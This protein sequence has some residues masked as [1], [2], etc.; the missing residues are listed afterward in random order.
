MKPTKLN[1]LGIAVHDLD[2]AARIYQALGLY[3]EKIVDVPEQQVR[4]A[5][6]PVGESTIEL[7][8]PT[9][10]DSTIARFL[11]KN[12]EGLHHL[13]LQVSDVQ[14]SLGELQAQ[15]IQ[16]INEAPRHGAEG[17]IAFLHPKSTGRVLIELVETT[18]DH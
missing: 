1:H 9:S 3:V 5:F 18:A 12:G 4:V 16:L 13:A 7:V 8:Q 17:L 6:I 10:P 2:A 15:G 11:E 14:A